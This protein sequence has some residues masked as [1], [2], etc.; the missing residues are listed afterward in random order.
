MPWVGKHEAV[1]FL[2]NL[3]MGFLTLIAIIAPKEGS[4]SIIQIGHKEGCGFL[5]FTPSVFVFFFFFLLFF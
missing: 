1:I 2:K 3:D 4:P 5:A